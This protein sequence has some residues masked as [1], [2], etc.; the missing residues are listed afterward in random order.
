MQFE[1]I[2]K[3]DISDELKLKVTDLVRENEVGILRLS[4]K[5]YCRKPNCLKFKDD[6]T[7]LAVVL[8]AAEK[9]LI[10]YKELGIEEKI[11]F[12]TMDD[13]RIWC[14]NNSDKGL[15]NY[16][17]IKNHIYCELFKIGRLQ[18][19]LYKCKNKTLNYKKLPF[20]YGE[21][22]IYVH[23]P[24]GEK[25]N[26][27]DCVESINEAGCFFAKYFPKHKFNYFFCE[28]WL[29]YENNKY[30]MS[31]ESNIIKFQSL[32]DIAYSLNLDSQGIERIFGKKEKDAHCYKQETSLQ[33]A[34]KEYM[35]NGGKLGIGIGCIK[36]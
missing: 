5:F 10:K 21:K 24:Q 4:K 6:L 17:W 22:L 33:K 2:D 8:A 23:I 31:S 14:E 27:D 26:L 1:L 18:F 7:R 20:K 19:Q 36:A 3:I 16:R 30:F 9:T 34:A 35:L 25:L 15:S 32:F 28:S 12:D 11:F 29:L 13:I